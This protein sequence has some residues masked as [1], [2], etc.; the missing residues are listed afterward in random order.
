MA[1]TA[2]KVGSGP[3]S[4][5][6]ER[7]VYKL[8]IRRGA[9]HVVVK[10]PA[11]DARTERIAKLFR[12]L[13]DASIP[14]FL[15]KLHRA[16]VT[17]AVDENMLERAEECLNHLGADWT[18]RRDLAL[19]DVVASSMRDLTG[20]MVGIADALEPTGARLYAVG[21]S[22]NSV[23]CLLAGDKLDVAVAHLNAA[24]GLEAENE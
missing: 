24:F 20:V 9:A 3:V 19:I 1:V 21:D 11:A 15:I 13:A 7:G 12:E 5:E 10:V 8:V 2:H 16:A 22:H 23:Q 14:I 18:T 17:F 4:F 6:R